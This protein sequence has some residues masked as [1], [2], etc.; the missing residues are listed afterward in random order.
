MSVF[1][2]RHRLFTCVFRAFAM[3]KAGARPMLSR[4]QG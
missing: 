1:W 4:R 2:K 3:K